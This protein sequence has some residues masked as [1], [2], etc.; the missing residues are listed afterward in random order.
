[1]VN[2]KIELLSPAGNLASFKAAC[3]GGADAIYMGLSKFNARQMAENFDV[4]KYIECIEY[5]HYRGIKVYLTLNTLLYD[6]EI[7]EAIDL[8]IKL[9]SRGLDAV[10]IQDIGLAYILH[11]ILP[12]LHLH[13][14]TQMS[15]Y[16]KSQV[17]FLVI[18]TYF[19]KFLLFL[20]YFF[21]V[22]LEFA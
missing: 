21:L 2:K 16:S 1:M 17:K 20:Q 8:V 22:L 18:F 4:E 13:A 3:I 9:Y 15:V 5:A 11:K 10:I 7:K 12:D 6:S 19:I 14:S